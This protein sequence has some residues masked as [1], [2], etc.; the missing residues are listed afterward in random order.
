MFQQREVEVQ[1][2]QESLLFQ[3]PDAFDEA[4]NTAQQHI[5]PP[6]DVTP[7]NVDVAAETVNVDAAAVTVSPIDPFPPMFDRLTYGARLITT[8]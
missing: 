8:K 7:V 5:Q 2:L 1:L 3:F 4:R 6:T